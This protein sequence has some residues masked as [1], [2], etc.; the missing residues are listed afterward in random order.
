MGGIPRRQKFTVASEETAFL[1]QSEAL[2]PAFSGAIHRRFDLKHQ[3]LQISGPLLT[4]LSKR[5]EFA[6][7]VSIAQAV[8]SGAA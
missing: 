4:R 3:P 7:V 2:E 8:G 5:S 1:H 6:Q